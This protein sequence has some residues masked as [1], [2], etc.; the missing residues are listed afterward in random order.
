MWA[1]SPWRV[2]EAPWGGRLY[3]RD[4]SLPVYLFALQKDGEDRLNASLT[5]R[6][7]FGDGGYF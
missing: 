4:L 5:L 6:A 1:C 3:V 2:V 7:D